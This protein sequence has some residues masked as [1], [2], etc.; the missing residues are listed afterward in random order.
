MR[1]LFLISNY[2]FKTLMVK[3]LILSRKKSVYLEIQLWFFLKLNWGHQIERQPSYPLDYTWSNKIPFL[4]HLYQRFSLFSWWSTPNVSQ[5][6][7]NKNYFSSFE[8][9]TSFILMWHFVKERSSP[10]IG[11]WWIDLVPNMMVWNQG[12][13]YNFKSMLQVWMI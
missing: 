10:K 12:V 13:E 2:F 6:L 3:I 7:F 9:S 4:L 1:A 8:N 5:F 11:R